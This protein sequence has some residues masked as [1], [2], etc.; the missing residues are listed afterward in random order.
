MTSASSSRLDQ[1]FEAYFVVMDGLNRV[2]AHKFCNSKSPEDYLPSLQGLQ[3]RFA[4]LV[5]RD[6]IGC[7]PLHSAFLSLLAG[8]QKC[9]VKVLF[10]DQ[11]CVD[12]KTF[13]SV[14]PDALVGSLTVA[15]QPCHLMAGNRCGRTFF[16]RSSCTGAR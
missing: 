8:M 14:F 16:T 9:D 11:C 4:E 7:A 10:T 15:A 13:H 2:V 6:L 5:R 1:C 12:S 3:R